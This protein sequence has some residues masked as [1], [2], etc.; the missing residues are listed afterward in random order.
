MY[1][2]I[3]SWSSKELSIPTNSCINNGAWEVV[4]ADKFSAPHQI[5][6]TIA[7]IIIAEESSNS[8]WDSLWSM[9]T[10]AIGKG[11][12]SFHP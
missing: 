9:I 7:V 10:N 12:N 3:P 2:R 5:I 8:G 1:F 4:Q 11:M 6:I